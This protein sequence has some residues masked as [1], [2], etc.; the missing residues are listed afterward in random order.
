MEK[1][2]CEKK[3]VTNKNFNKKYVT[4]IGWY[5]LASSLM[6]ILQERQK[7]I[8]FSRT[9]IIN[10]SEKNL[11]WRTFFFLAWRKRKR[12]RFYIKC[13]H[14]HAHYNPLQ[15]NGESGGQAVRVFVPLTSSL[16]SRPEVKDNED[17]GCKIEEKA[18]NYFIPSWIRRDPGYVE[19]PSCG[20]R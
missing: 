14:T 13:T 5:T 6:C 19:Y 7:T 12:A 4:M 17:L 18:A 11:F 9:V 1:K 20:Y 3:T 10:I 16:T 15:R 8:N 2:I